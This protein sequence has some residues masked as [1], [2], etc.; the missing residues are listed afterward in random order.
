MLER[1]VQVGQCLR[2]D[3]LGGVDDEQRAFARSQAAGDLVREV[4]VTRGVD[5]IEDVRLVRSRR[6]VYVRRTACS[7]IVMPRSF[8][9]SIWSRS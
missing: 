1:E 5:Q 7:L 4:D 9:K 3:P 8:S 6:G 2:L